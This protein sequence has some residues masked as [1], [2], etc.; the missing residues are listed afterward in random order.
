M[1]KAGFYAVRRGRQP[2]VYST[3]EECKAQVEGFPRAEYKRFGNL[4]DAEGFI[5]VAYI[6]TTLTKS[7]QTYE[8]SPSPSSV[9][10]AS[11]RP[12]TSTSVASAAPSTSAAAR[13]KPY[14]TA[15]S[16]GKV[17]VEESTSRPISRDEWTTAYTDGACRGNG[18][19]GAVA[20]IGVWYG[21]NDPRNVSERCPGTQTNN[22]AELIAI[23]RC[24]ETD[25]EPDQGLQIKSDSKYA[26]DCVT[27]WMPGWERN[28]WR[29]KDKKDVSNKAVIQHLARLLD[30]RPG[31][32][33]F[34]YVKGHS[35][36]K[37]NDGADELAGYGASLPATPEREWNTSSAQKD[38]AITTSSKAPTRNSLGVLPNVDVVEESLRGLEGPLF[39][40]EELEEL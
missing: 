14:P 1:P 11:S 15:I 28:G 3:W 6:E 7:A 27:K 37:G 18:A 5:G 29:T 35:G 9:S 31:P 33:R 25:L 36:E 13:F 21:D 24:L 16:K 8:D 12:S 34:E 32:V 38:A 4:K 22:R 39:D 2:G 23:I 40:D 26:M 17:K 19:V 20:G 30:E 10:S